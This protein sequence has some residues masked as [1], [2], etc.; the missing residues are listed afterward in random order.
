MSQC[1]FRKKQLNILT[2]VQNNKFKV[3]AQ[4]ADD[5]VDAVIFY[6]NHK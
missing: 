2:V 6:H 1:L 4:L 5:T 3:N